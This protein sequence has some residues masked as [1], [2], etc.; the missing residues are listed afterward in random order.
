MPLLIALCG[1]KPPPDRQ[2]FMV[3]S[4][5]GRGKELIAQVGC[6]ACHAIPGIGWPKG[7]LG[8]PLRGFADQ[9]LIAG[10][11]PNT[12]ENLA[13]FVRNAPSV[14]PRSAMPAMPLT[15]QESRD[16]AAYL[17]TLES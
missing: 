7:T 12:P 4:D 17:Y 10:R 5:P 14:A 3:Q 15:P 9:A 2:H 6:G 13:L 16:V 8:P 11:V 1:C